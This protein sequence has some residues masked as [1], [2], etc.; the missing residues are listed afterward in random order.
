[1]HLFLIPLQMSTNVAA[2]DGVSGFPVGH[3]RG[4]AK[5]RGWDA[6][7]QHASLQGRLR[8]FS[9]LP[10]QDSSPEVSVDRRIENVV[11]MS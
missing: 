5:H 1:M 3:S 8:S 2:K 9:C 4:A 7:G 11:W 10:W 6:Q